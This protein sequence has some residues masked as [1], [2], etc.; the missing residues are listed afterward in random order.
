MIIWHRGT[1]K[2]AV[3]AGGGD[4][5]GNQ[6]ILRQIDELV[7]IDVKN[8]ELHFKGESGADNYGKIPNG[9]NQTKLE[10]QK[11]QLLLENTIMPVV[12][13]LIFGLILTKCGGSTGDYIIEDS[14]KRYLDQKEIDKLSEDEKMMASF[15]ILARHGVDF[16]FV[17]DGEKIQKY[18]EK[19]LGM[20]QWSIMLPLTIVI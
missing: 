9:L 11:K 7:I 3:A 6:E 18:F 16:S 15:E 4:Y 19:S 8:N 1:V 20:C 10:K 17:Q 2:K 5:K 13:V 12:L 14:S